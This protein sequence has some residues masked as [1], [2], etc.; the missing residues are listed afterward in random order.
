MVVYRLTGPVDME[1][2]TALRLTDALR[3]AAMRRAQEALGEVPELL[4]GHGPDGKPSARP[5][6]AYAA[7]PFVSEVQEHA[8]GRVLGVAVVLPRDAAL[9][10]CRRAARPLAASDHHAV[11]GVGRR[12]LDRLTPDRGAPRNL[13]PEAW[14]GPA[15]RWSSVTPVVLDRFPKRGGRGAAAILARACA[16]VGLPRPAEVALD[17]FSPLHGVEP[18]FRFVTR[19]GRAAEPGA[20]RLYAHV[21][22]AFERPVR[23]PVL[24]GARRHF[25]LGLLRPLREGPP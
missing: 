1:I 14:E 7:L 20:P 24:L 16:H 15:R 12:G 9:A 8:D 4:S 2:E 17:H 5:H 10:E 6:A 22:L 25:G 3:A 11:P 13:R 19:R 23:G 21:A 18:S